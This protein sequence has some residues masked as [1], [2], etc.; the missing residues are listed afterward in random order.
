MNLDEEY[1]HLQLRFAHIDLFTQ[2]RSK[3]RS[4]MLEVLLI[5]KQNMK[6]KV[7]QEKGHHLPHIHIDYGNKNHVASYAIETGERL[8]GNLS[9]KYDKVV[10]AWLEDN[11]EKVLKGWNE[12]QAGNT[13]DHIVAQLNADE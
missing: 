8:D 5:K 13:I 12:L 4:G 2:P 1:G 3:S 9:K 6:I 11:R 7:Y 10:I